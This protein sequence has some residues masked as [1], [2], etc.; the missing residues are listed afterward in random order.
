MTNDCQYLCKFGVSYKNPGTWD[1]SK[2]DNY[3]YIESTHGELY[4]DDNIVLLIDKR[5]HHKCRQIS[6][7]L[8]LIERNNYRGEPLRIEYKVTS[9]KVCDHIYEYTIDT[10]YDSLSGF[11]ELNENAMIFKTEGAY[12]YNGSFGVLASKKE[13]SPHTPAKLYIF[14][15]NCAIDSNICH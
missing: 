1:W 15:K 11:Y 13:F 14:N 6:N 9:K 3:N 10:D 4:R 8:F 5:I 2:G 12:V 7:G